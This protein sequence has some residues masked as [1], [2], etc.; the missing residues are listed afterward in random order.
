MR[1]SPKPTAQL[2]TGSDAM[3]RRTVK[4]WEAGSTRSAPTTRRTMTARLP[5]MQS[6]EKTSLMSDR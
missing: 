1:P 2:S 4:P 5:R 6:V 3:A